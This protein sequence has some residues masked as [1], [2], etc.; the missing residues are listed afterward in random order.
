MFGI[1]I[2]TNIQRRDMVMHTHPQVD[3]LQGFK[4][5]KAFWCRSRSVAQQI[6]PLCLRLRHRHQ[7][8]KKGEF[9]VILNCIVNISRN[10]GTSWEPSAVWWFGWS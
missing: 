6:I 1:L 7:V 9:G 8:M 2:K 10:F 4:L 5:G 3:D